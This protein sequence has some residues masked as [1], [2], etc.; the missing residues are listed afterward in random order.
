MYNIHTCDHA[1]CPHS[2]RLL[3]GTFATMI[4]IDTTSMASSVP[5]LNVQLCCDY[6][7]T[8]YNIMRMQIHM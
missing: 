1:T 8:I 3:W 2:N 7:A 6:C 5:L 4:P